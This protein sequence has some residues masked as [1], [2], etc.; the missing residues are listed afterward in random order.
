MKIAI[1][2][3]D[4][5]LLD[6]G[7]DITVSINHVRAAL[8]GLQPLD[9]AYVI[10]AINAHQRNLAQLFYETQQYES[11]AQ[12]LFEA[13][14]YEQCTQ[15]VRLY[16]GVYETLHTLKENRVHLCV[17]TNAP[18]VFATRMLTHLCVAPLFEHI[19]GADMVETPK[20]DKQML[21]FILN[22]YGFTHG[23]DSA[24]MIGDNSKDMQSASG[25]NIGSIFATWGFSRE[26]EGHH[27]ADHPSK[28]IDIIHA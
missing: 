17:A 10:A 2:D 20:P 25:A 19:V 15:H 7:Y 1:F 16:E 8:Y 9:V 26:G 27:R 4:G 18:T 11:S 22:R 23:N 28:V 13:H 3:M 24:W 6:S 21:E 5:T 14:Y 12:Q